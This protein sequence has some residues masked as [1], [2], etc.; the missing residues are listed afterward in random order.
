MRGAILIPVLM[1]GACSMGE[2]SESKGQPGTR[3]FQVGAF[4][5]ISL[6][7][8]PERHRHGRRR[9]VGPGRGRQ[10]AAREARGHGRER[11]PP[12]RLQEGQL[13][14]RLAQGP[15]AGDV[16]VSAPS[17]TGA[18]VAG[19]GDMKIDKV[20]GG[21]FAGEIAGSGEI[22][23]ASLR[24]RNA[25]FSIAGSGGVT[26][27]GTAETADVRHRRLGRRPRRRAPGEERQG[28]DRRL[29]QC[30][31]Q[32]DGERQRRHHGLGRRRRHRRRQMQRQQDGLGRA[33]AAGRIRH[34]GESRDDGALTIFR[35]GPADDQ[36][37]A[38]RPSR[39]RRRRPGR[40]RRADL[41]GHRLRPGAGR[42]T[43]SGRPDD[44][45]KLFRPGRRFGRG[46]RPCRRSTCRAAP[47]G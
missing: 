25:S 18:E 30:R 43:L 45:P 35:Q 33:C 13:V 4:D 16:H 3:N 26:A 34:P 7:G 46:A 29:R 17:L 11:N 12:D 14:V 39:P 5:R 40:R 32:G 38:A 9:A 24:A 47:F 27:S 41:F 20:E 15:W 22:Q 44:R 8:S 37:P 10:Q 19:S 36:D 21:D 6:L 28:V 23:L 2:A 42:R 31:D 1:L